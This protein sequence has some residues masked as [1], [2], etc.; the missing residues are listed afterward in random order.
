[1]LGRLIEVKKI[2][3]PLEDFAYLSPDKPGDR[4]IALLLS[5]RAPSPAVTIHLVKLLIFVLKMGYY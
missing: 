2:E 4:L 1:V 3:R 5:G